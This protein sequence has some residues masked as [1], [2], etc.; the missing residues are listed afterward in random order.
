MATAIAGL[1]VV[2]NAAAASFSGVTVAKDSKRKAA[3]V[4]SGGTARTVRLAGRFGQVRLGQ[5]VAVTATK[6]PD[7]TYDA[8]RVRAL[9]R[10]KHARF[11]AVVVKAERRRVI[12]SAGG[13]VFAVGLRSGGRAMASTSAGGLATGDRVVASIGLSA[14]ATWSTGMQETGRSKL[15]ELEGIFLAKK[16]DGFDVAVVERGAVHV[17]VPEGAVLPD[18]EPGDQISMLVLIGKDGSFTFIRGKDE[19]DHRPGKPHHKEGIQAE[20]VLAE[21]AAYSV[22]VRTEGDTKV[23]CAVPSGMDLSLFRVGERVKIHCVSRENRDV[24][25]KIQSNYGWVKADGT[26]QLSVHGAL[27]KGNGTVSVRREDGMTVSCSVPNGVDLS[28]FRAG[29]RVKLHCNLGEGGFVFG[30]IYSESASLDEHGVLLVYASGLLQARTDVPVTV[31]RPDGSMF[32][33]NAPADFDLSYF[34]AGEPVSLTCRVDSGVNTLLR[35]RSERY[36]VG[37]DGS[38]ELYLHGTLD[39]KT[40]TS[41]TV[42]GS[43]GHTVTCQVP[44]GTDLSAFGVGISVKVHCHKRDGLFRLAY[45]K[46]ESA[47]IELER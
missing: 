12:L 23:E 20:G 11:A 33:C 6:R 27:S 8:R 28:P 37:A 26:G 21:K 19:S 44:A 47:V 31:R 43:D 9:G 46:S 29:E 22:V 32:S 38:V 35:A 41:V 17:E 14:A 13:S 7:G 45:M 2:P 36:E 1:L 5:R 3:V 34:T 18:F 15:V 10:A 16:G 40:E 42:R 30:S 25:I 39:A 4:V 24:L